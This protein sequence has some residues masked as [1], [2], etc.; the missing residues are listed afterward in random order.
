V[1]RNERIIAIIPARGGSKGLPRKNILPL[2]GKPVIAYTIEAAK[3]ERGLF[4]EI[5]VSTDDSE[6]AAVVRQY[7]AKVLMRP[8]Q[9][10]TDTCPID[11][12]LRHA[13]Q[14][15]ETKS[16]PVG[17]VVWLQA[18]C[19]HRRPG[20]IR[21]AVDRL[22]ETNADCAMTVVPY[23]VPPQWAWRLENDK[24]IRLEGCYSYTVRRQET[25][26]AFH[27]TGAV[28]AIRR[29]VLMNSEGLSEGAY[30][31][32]DRRAIIEPDEYGIEIDEPFDLQLCELILS[33]RMKSVSASPDR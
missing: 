12:T 5:I 21:K 14:W 1:S 19:P 7:A 9:F 11:P 33:R 32:D 24:M 15:S 30:L 10:A 31:G 27:P 20:S 16:G 28:V 22:L 4:D 17:I 8:P 23:R 25:V 6:I 13:V 2:L 3:E 29:D 26:P 18:N